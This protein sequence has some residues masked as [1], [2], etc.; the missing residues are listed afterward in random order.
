MT[1]IE[2]VGALFSQQRERITELEKR[3]ATLEARPTGLRYCGVWEPFGDYQK[4]DGCTYH[5]SL[6]VALRASSGE[7]PEGS[8]AWRLCCKRG[9]DGRDAR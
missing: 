3:V 4:D 8:D 2:R 6:W 1:F 5:G 7:A 9:R